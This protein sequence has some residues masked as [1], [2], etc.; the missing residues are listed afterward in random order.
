VPRIVEACLS[1]AG[2]LQQRLPCVIVG[3]RLDGVSEPICE[4][5]TRLYPELTSSRPLLILFVAVIF[6]ELDQL[7]RQPDFPLAGTGLDGSVVLVC[8]YTASAAARS[9]AARH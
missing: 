1:H 9:L 8:L 5:S 6:Q 4:D 7:G 3:V 2:T